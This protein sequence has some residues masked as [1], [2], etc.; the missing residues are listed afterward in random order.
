[1]ADQSDAVLA[2]RS[3][4]RQQLLRQSERQRA[5]LTNYI[6]V[7]ANTVRLYC[8]ASTSPWH[9]ARSDPHADPGDTALGHGAA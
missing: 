6:L 1:M 3:E 4:H 2:Y 7:I 9:A 5:V 8:A